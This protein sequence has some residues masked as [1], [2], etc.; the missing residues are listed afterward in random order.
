M[1]E[2]KLSTC[3]QAETHCT[4]CVLT[5]LPEGYIWQCSAHLEEERIMILLNLKK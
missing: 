4:N 2:N 5:K 1:E 3:E